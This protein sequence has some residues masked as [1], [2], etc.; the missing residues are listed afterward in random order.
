MN[1]S[2]KNELAGLLSKRKMASPLQSKRKPAKCQ[3]KRRPQQEVTKMQNRY[4][5]SKPRA[6]L[7]W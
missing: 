7:T 4:M 2:K 6:L 1:R 3:H 5:W